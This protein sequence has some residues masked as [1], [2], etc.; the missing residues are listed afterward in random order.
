MSIVFTADREGRTHGAPDV[1]REAKHVL[2]ALAVMLLMVAVVFVFNV[3]N[4]NML[5]I[6]GLAVFT[7]IYGFPAGI[8]CGLVMIVYSMYFFSTD[9]S[10]FSYTAINLQ[11]IG[12]IVLGVVLNT[13]FIGNLKHRQSEAARRLHEMNQ[14][15][16]Q[17]NRTLEAASMTDDL[18]GIRNR[19]ALRRDYSRFEN[20]NVHV[21]MLDLDNFKALND[22]F[23]HSVGDHILRRLSAVLAETFGSEWCYRYGGDE[24]LVVLPDVSEGAFLGKLEALKRGVR[25]ID[26]EDQRLPVH[27]SAGY[28]HGVCELSYDLRLMMHQA[29][30]NLYD[31][32]GLGKDCYV[33]RAF[34]RVFAESLPEEADGFGEGKEKV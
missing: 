16:Q 4:P 1:K 32:K 24:F 12:V 27:F 19:F 14:E 34:S 23:G 29:D 8:A 2:I 7:S 30:S 6:T 31:A 21:M 26:M 22:Q 17:D 5:L 9:H 18:T 33:G 10:F 13:A 28:V 20:R 11:K 25:S 3:P 15:L